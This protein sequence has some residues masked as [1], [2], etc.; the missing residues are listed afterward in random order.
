MYRDNFFPDRVRMILMSSL[1]LKKFGL[2]SSGERT[3]TSAKELFFTFADSIENNCC[4][5]SKPFLLSQSV[6]CRLNICVCFCVAVSVCV[7]LSVPLLLLISRLLWIGFWWIGFS[8][9]D[10]TWWKCWN[11][12]PIHCATPLDLC[13]TRKACNGSKGPLMI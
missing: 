8:D 5:W 7:C 10:Q 11:F 6:D 12:C 1:F 4:D 3:A 9:F 2:S 13:T